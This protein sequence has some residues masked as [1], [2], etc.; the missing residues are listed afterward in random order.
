[1]AGAPGPAAGDATDKSNS[2]GPDRCNA[3]RLLF[4]KRPG[5]KW[6]TI[7]KGS[8]IWQRRPIPRSAEACRERLLP[9]SL[10]LCDH[11]A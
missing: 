7:S 8:W 1:M 11:A 9:D 2:F 4:C 5:P 6:S 3:C 10:G